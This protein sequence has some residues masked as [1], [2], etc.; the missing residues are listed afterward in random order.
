MDDDIS[1]SELSSSSSS[2][3][4]FLPSV[5]FCGVY[6]FGYSVFYFVYRSNMTGT[7]QTVQYYGYTMLV[8]YVFFLML[9][10]V[11][12]F[13]ALAFTKFIYRNLKLD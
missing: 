1:A 9:G 6:V 13:S 7:L 4:F 3:F 11:G 12:F 5:R 10:T 2:S 8:C